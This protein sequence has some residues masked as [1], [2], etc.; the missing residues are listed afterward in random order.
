MKNS[1]ESLGRIRLQGIVLLLLTFAVGVLAGLA[2][3]R[4]MAARRPPRFMPPMSMGQP[5]VKGPL[6][7]MFAELELTL[8]QQS[9][10]R[11]IIERSRPRTEELLQQTMPHLRALT[12]SVRLEIQAVLTPEQAAR[13]DSLMTIRGRGPGRMPG[14]RGP[15]TDRRRSREP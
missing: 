2:L 1:V 12:D 7:P 11:D 9:Q 6:P 8:E 13:L 4:V 14:M 10:I 15:G 3:E 5:W